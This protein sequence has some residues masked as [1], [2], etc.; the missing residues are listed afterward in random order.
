MSALRIIFIVVGVVLLGVMLFAHV[1]IPG[2]EL[3]IG[4][5][6]G[7]VLV[8]AGLRGRVF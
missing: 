5:V 4:I 8:I 6:V 7:A 2:I 3:L 1:L